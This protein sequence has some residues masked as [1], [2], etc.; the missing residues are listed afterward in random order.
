MSSNSRSNP[1]KPVL[2]IDSPMTRQEWR[3]SLSL[4]AIYMLRMLGMFLIL[5]VF[6]VLARG[7]PDA[8]P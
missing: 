4:A 6:S 5:P 3:A 8:T 7:L 2:D 1:L